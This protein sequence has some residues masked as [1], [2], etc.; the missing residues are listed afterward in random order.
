[1]QKLFKS[2]AARAPINRKL[3]LPVQSTPIQR[4][5]STSQTEKCTTP[6]NQS[7]ADDLSYQEFSP[8]NKVDLDLSS[9]DSHI[10]SNMN[11]SIRNSHITHDQNKF[12]DKLVEEKELLMLQIK[13][14]RMQLEQMSIKMFRIQEENQALKK[15]NFY[16]Q[17]D[18]AESNAKLRNKNRINGM[19]IEKIQFDNE[20]RKI[21]IGNELT[22]IEERIEQNEKIL[23]KLYKRM[24]Q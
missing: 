5:M 21:I 15:A 6:N 20:D 9:S 8:T 1:M 14:Q 2:M 10:F 16:L 13:T 18:L 24:D 4:K 19:K 22:N 7:V 23:Q 17:A 11:E 12:N 3:E